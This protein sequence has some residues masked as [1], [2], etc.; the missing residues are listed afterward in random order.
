MVDR[1]LQ[2][3]AS[4]NSSEPDIRGSYVTPQDPLLRWLASKLCFT[5]EKKNAL[6][7]KVNPRS[8]P[9]TFRF[10]NWAYDCVAASLLLPAG[11]KAHLTKGGGI[12][13]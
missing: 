5:L 6:D 8:L 13:D 2:L 7:C 10:M 4:Y 12:G 11:T 1:V 9:T 3:R